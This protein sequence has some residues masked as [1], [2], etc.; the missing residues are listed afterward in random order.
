MVLQE[1]ALGRLN[2]SVS[3]AEEGFYLEYV[4]VHRSHEG[5]LHSRGGALIPTREGLF[6]TVSTLGKENPWK[7]IFLEDMG[8]I[9][10]TTASIIRAN[11][12]KH[13]HQVMRRRNKLAN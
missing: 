2:V 10:L 5:E 4:G 6:E 7:N 11:L 13:N 12:L 9:D 3:P 8:G 1:Y